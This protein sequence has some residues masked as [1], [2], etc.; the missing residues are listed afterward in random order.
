V[1]TDHDGIVRASTQP[2]QGETVYELPAGATS[3]VEQDDLATYETT[4]PSG[5]EGFLFSTPIFFQQTE[6]GR[7]YLGINRAGMD[8]VL[9]STL[10]L[11]AIGGVLTVISVVGMLYVFGGLLARP[12]RRLS[13]MLLSF[14]E[15]DLDSRISE[16]RND[17]IGELFRAFNSMAD[18]LQTKYASATF[19]AVKDDDLQHDAIE[20][21]GDAE[22]TLV[23]QSKT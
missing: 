3:V 17:E 19:D 10:L 9:Q 12:L 16:T 4:L 2:D 7:V 18:M 15:G 11:L 23:V 21:D 20:F 8:S 13:R 22:M 14:G 1:I 6:I 5:V